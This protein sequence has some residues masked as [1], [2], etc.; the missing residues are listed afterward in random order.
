MDSDARTS[1]RVPGKERE[2]EHQVLEAETLAPT[3]IR[4]KSHPRAHTCDV[5]CVRANI[6]GIHLPVCHRVY[7]LYDVYTKAAR[8]KPERRRE[9]ERGY[10]RDELQAG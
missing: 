8:K 7:I 3:H 4:A 9:R 1:K 2:S 5:S 10:V 6:T